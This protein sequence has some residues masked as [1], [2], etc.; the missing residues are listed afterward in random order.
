MEDKITI[1]C[2]GPGLGFYIPG[3]I[4]RRQLNE[5]GLLA[6]VEVFENFIIEEK[7]KKIPDARLSFHRN[8]KFAL[9]GQKVIRDITPSLDKIRVS[10][11]LSTWKNEKR[12]HFIIFS[13]FWIPIIQQYVQD[14]DFNVISIVLCHVDSDYS[15]SWKLY[16]NKIDSYNHIWLCNYDKKEI[17]YQLQISEHQSIPYEDRDFRFVVHGGGWGMGTYKEEIVE[18]NRLGLRLDIIN[19]ETDDFRIIKPQNRYYMIDP[20]WNHW[21]KDINGYYQFPPFGRIIDNK[22]IDFKKNKKYPEVYNL[23]RKSK[24]IIS[25]PGAGTLIDSLSSATPILFLEPFGEYEKKN[26]LLWEY[27]GFG[28]QCKEWINNGASFAVLEKLSN[29]I[30]RAKKHIKNFTEVYYANQNSG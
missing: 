4:V 26:A 9:M 30:L 6:D 16:K 20:N 29:N 22:K 21:D 8:F 5:K 11:L 13:G 12:K 3:L 19:Y 24:A 25:K 14:I 7:R 27:Y 23:I 17:Q 1:L 15:S 28:M 2:A 10:N 18:L